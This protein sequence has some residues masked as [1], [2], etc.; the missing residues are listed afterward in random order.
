[1]EGLKAHRAVSPARQ[2]PEVV[3]FAVQLQPVGNREV[4]EGRDTEGVTQQLPR[5][6]LGIHKVISMS[7]SMS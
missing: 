3:D 7:P 6:A 2:D 5:R 4:E 1:M